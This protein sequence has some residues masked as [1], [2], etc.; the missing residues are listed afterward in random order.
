MGGVVI[1]PPDPQAESI[2]AANSTT[3]APISLRVMIRPPFSIDRRSRQAVDLEDAGSC[4]RVTDGG[5]ASGGE[6]H[7]DLIVRNVCLPVEGPIR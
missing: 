1:A 4:L 6:A 3:T 2:V 5:V 7:Y